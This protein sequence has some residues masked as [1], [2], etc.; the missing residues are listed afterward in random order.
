MRSCIAETSVTSRG[1]GETSPVADNST[2]EGRQRNRRLEI[3]VSG[4]VIALKIGKYGPKTSRASDSAQLLLNC[5][6]G[7]AALQELPMNVP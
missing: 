4:E 2:A 5:S 3:V 1:L 7:E 6:Q